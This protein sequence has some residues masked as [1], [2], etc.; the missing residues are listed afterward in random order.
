MPRDD[1]KRASNK[2]TAKRASSKKAYNE[3]CK[4][5]ARIKKNTKRTKSQES[6][7]PS[8]AVGTKDFPIPPMHLQD[9]GS[10]LGEVRTY[11]V[12]RWGHFQEI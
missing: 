3:A 6:K 4:Q 12:S 2:Q 7:N 5:R 11:H 1:W 9:D 10:Y 8:Y